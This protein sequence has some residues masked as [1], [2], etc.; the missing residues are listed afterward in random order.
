MRFLLPYCCRWVRFTFRFDLFRRCLTHKFSENTCSFFS[1]LNWLYQIRFEINSYLIL[2]TILITRGKF[3]ENFSCCSEVSL[4]F[5]IV[6][7]FNSCRTENI[8]KVGA[9]FRRRF[10]SAPRLSMR[11]FWV[12]T[13]LFLSWLFQKKGYS[14]KLIFNFLLANISQTWKSNLK[15]DLICSKISYT[16]DTRSNHLL[17]LHPRSTKSCRRSHEFLQSCSAG[18]N[19]ALDSSTCLQVFRIAVPILKQVWYWKSQW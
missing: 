1:F 11:N 15:V 13:R 3:E 12:F 4:V 5:Q 9:D 19:S 18:I 2:N 17:Q 8:K 6:F 16:S 10:E 7:R 14:K